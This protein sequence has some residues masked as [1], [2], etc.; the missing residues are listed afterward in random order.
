MGP[1]R[2]AAI[3]LLLTASSLQFQRNTQSVKSRR[4]GE[5]CTTGQDLVVQALELLKAD[6]KSPAIED[7][8]QLLRR[9]TDLCAESG[10]AW[11]YRSLVE[12]RLH[13]APLAALAL[14][15]A[16]LFPSDALRES[17]NPFVLATPA[18][19]QAKPDAHIRQRWALVVGIG[20]FADQRIPELDYTTADATAF[21]D[22]LIDPALGG[23]APAN[24]RLLTDSG[25]SLVEIKKGLNWLARSATPDDLVVVYIASHG[26]PR[27]IDTAGANYI[28]VNDTELDPS[29]V[30]PDALY[31]SALAMVDLSNAVAT[32]LKSLRTAVFLDTC[33]S[34]GA[35]TSTSRNSDSA[36][37]K[38]AV[39]KATLEHITQ[40]MGRVI[41]A[42][43]RTD[44]ESLESSQLKHGYFTYYL[45]EALRKSPSMPLSQIFSYV[46][47]HVSQRV[48]TD[49]ALYDMHQTPV[50][51]QSADDADFALGVSNLS[52]TAHLEESA[53]WRR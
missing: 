11:Y 26:S 52:N 20:H 35:I 2:C 23:F 46:Q 36:L 53:K 37:S 39:S 41:F 6:S 18:P 38:A 51:S 44:Q 3:V 9:A 40:G 17:L 19:G 31:A 13:H 5:S 33:Y 16:N 7:A 48:D 30:D 34:G 1:I 45:V 42:A 27:S 50:L 29:H 25:A 32:R 47:E 49:Y 10:E 43:S 21:R 24:V 22:V 15:Q 12:A 14:R 4:A 8:N 28:V